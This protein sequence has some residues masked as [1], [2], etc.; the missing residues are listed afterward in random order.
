MAEDSDWTPDFG[1]ISAE[2]PT[3]PAKRPV[4]IALLGDFG[5]GALSGR[6]DTGDALARRKP[7]KVEFDTLEDALARLDLKL[8]LPLGADGAPVE[9]PITELESFH[10]DELYRNLEVF[11]ALAS[12]RKRLKTPSSFAKAAAEVRSWAGGGQRKASSLNR[13]ARARGAAL[14][15]G[16][17]QSDFARLT[18]RKPSAEAAGTDMDA[19][20][21]NIVG[22]FVVPAANPN[23]DA[24][25]ATVDQSLSDAMRAV[26]QQP[27]FQN[28]ESLWRGVDFLLRRL[29]TSHQ[30]QV[31]LIDLSAEE[32][33]ADLSAVSDL[34]DSGLYKLL[35]EQPSQDAD[36]G[37][38]Y[39][40][41]CYHFQ[42]TPPQI[43]LLGRAALV[44]AHAGAPFITAIETD[45]FTDRREPPH[46][47]VTQT[48]EALRALPDASFL[49]LIGPRFL[50]RHPYGK[51]SDPISSFNFEEFAASAGLRGMLWGHPALLALCVLAR[52][53][54]QLTID[55]LP[56]HFFVDGDGDTI[57]LPCTERL[58]NTAA[59]TLLRDHGI[60]AVLAH[61]GE[62]LV[63]LAG[64]EAVN[65]DGL[66]AQGGTARKPAS[67]TRFMLR[68]KSDGDDGDGPTAARASEARRGDSSG[69][70]ESD[71]AAEQASDDASETQADDSDESSNSDSAA[72]SASSDDQSLDDL[73]ASLGGSDDAS[74]DAASAKA[75]ETASAGAD[76]EMDPD[77]AALLK[78]LG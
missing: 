21:R 53:G 6:L 68:S 10:P 26:L 37:Y 52:P 73:L 46:K 75:S 60:N 57:A 43:E 23:V 3:W 27:D 51:R 44:A 48:L 65:G 55:D 25:V 1:G 22:P 70:P 30:L 12:L 33:A 8:T 49:G 40:V 39:L 20:L 59:S 28:V 78:S 47:L 54:A 13:T 29:E 41:G 19:L 16:G 2:P 42:A 67:D 38:T 14:A 9:V 45:P 77:L 11:S 24:L 4:R 50:L 7:L 56:F 36:G 69:K 34:S 31:H 64:L 58:I 15:A 5:A 18:G 61:K 72:G 35:V 71:E 76:D 32:L 74:A 17:K 63:R 66:P 62:A